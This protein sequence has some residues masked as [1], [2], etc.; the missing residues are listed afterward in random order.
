M[1]GQYRRTYID[2]NLVQPYR[3]FRHY[4]ANL[5]ATQN[6][7]NNIYR[8][9]KKMGKIQPHVPET[10]EFFCDAKNGPGKRSSTPPLSVN[11]VRPG[12][13]DIIAAIGDSLSAGSGS[14]SIG[15]HSL[16]NENRGITF[17]GGGR[18][19][20]RKYLT[21]PNIL[22]EF[23]SNLYGYSSED[24]LTIDR[25]SK[26]NVAEPITMFQDMLF[27]TKVLFKRLQRDPK[28]NMTSHW[29]MITIFIGNND[30][31]SKICDLPNP[32]SLI[33]DHVEDIYKTLRFLRDNV[34]RTIINWVLMPNLVLITKF[35]NV[36]LQCFIAERVE[37]RC[38]Y[39]RLATL[40]VLRRYENIILEMQKIQKEVIYKD[41]FHTDTFTVNIQT[42]TQNLTLPS[43]PN[44]DT[45]LRYFAS[46]CF[47]FSQLGQAA[48][49]NALWNNVMEPEGAKQINWMPAFAQFKCPT[50][51]R[52][53]IATRENSN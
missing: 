25:S 53:F 50:N 13:I 30:V 15:L 17:S 8:I 36:P 46:D 22:R 52:P 26:F 39:T 38:L 4:M 31:C 34:P 16:L 47:H 37:C 24:G 28:V 40:K 45:D 12:D 1:Q 32:E 2:S 6:E 41:E 35:K 20:W 48:A 14:I 23:N 11:E 44:G 29:K 5:T 33:E 10:R 51:E 7:I 49:A 3:M 43:L 42:F 9:N 18:S 27:Q 19:D 21:V